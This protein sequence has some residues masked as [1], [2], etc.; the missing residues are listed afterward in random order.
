MINSSAEIRNLLGL[1]RLVDPAGFTELSRKINSKSL[2]VGGI[3]G[4][5]KDSTLN[6]LSATEIC[7]C[8]AAALMRLR[9]VAEPA[10]VKVGR[11]LHTA[12]VIGLLGEIFA[13][14]AAAGVITAIWGAPPKDSIAHAAAVWMSVL[15]FCGSSASLLARFLRRDLAGTDG[16]LAATHRKLVDSVWEADTLS[17]KLDLVIAKGADHAASKEATALV[18]RAEKL[19]AELYRMV[20]D[21]G[22]EIGFLV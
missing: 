2:Q 6:A 15:A 4:E 14:L 3:L 16:G 18:E 22:V 9:R 20:T 12:N 7:V 11:R 13:A 10:L 5:G 17:I 8:A 21:T 19:A 1:F